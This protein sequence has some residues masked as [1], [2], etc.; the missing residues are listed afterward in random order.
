MNPHA[1]GVHRSRGSYRSTSGYHSRGASSLCRT[2]HGST[3][4]PGQPSST[5]RRNRSRSAAEPPAAAAPAFF[6][7]PL[8]LRAKSSRASSA[9]YFGR[10]STARRPSATNSA[11]SSEQP[12][13]AADATA[14]G[15]RLA[16]VP[17][18]ARGRGERKEV[19]VGHGVRHA[20]TGTS[21]S[22]SSSIARAHGVVEP[23]RPARRQSIAHGRVTRESLGALCVGKRRRLSPPR[24][25]ERHHVIQQRDR[26]ITL[27]HAATSLH[28]VAR[29]ISPSH[30]ADSSRRPA[31]RAP[32]A[33]RPPTAARRRR[34][35]AAPGR[36]P[37]PRRAAPRPPRRTTARHLAVPVADGLRPAA[38]AAALE[39]D[40][41]GAC[42]CTSPRNT[43]ARRARG[44]GVARVGGGENASSGA[45]SAASRR[46]QRE[47]LR[48][49]APCARSRAPGR[50]QPSTARPMR[51]RRALGGGHRVTARVHGQREPRSAG[52]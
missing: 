38:L 50:R 52:R 12:T 16:P 27:C 36:P 6:C 24:R 2:V 51:Y 31:R 47:R 26:P 46:E 43:L 42:H 49:R 39:R 8:T 1:S 45:G 40:G 48:R 32:R 18:P 28:A 34:S 33:P 9:A 14:T 13:Q 10:P 3:S 11:A 44:Q 19:E 29:V 25:V 21:Y 30:R 23:L 22:C 17:P 5:H 41:V 20:A 4:L 7:R 15:R 37:P 35:A